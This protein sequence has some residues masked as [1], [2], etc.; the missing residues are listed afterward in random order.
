M[1][2][3]PLVR[4]WMCLCFPEEVSIAV[5][6]PHSTYT[7]ECEEGEA[8]VPQAALWHQCDWLLCSAG[9]LFSPVGTLLRWVFFLAPMLITLCWLYFS[10]ELWLIEKISLSEVHIFSYELECTKLLPSEKNT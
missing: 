3:A 6:T 10:V 7:S 2:D 1:R 8:C 4:V 5:S 9:Q